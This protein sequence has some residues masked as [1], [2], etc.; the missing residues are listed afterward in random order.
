MTKTAKKKIVDGV[1]RL[2]QA[3]INARA[4]KPKE[5]HFTFQRLRKHGAPDGRVIRSLMADH[6]YAVWQ[7]LLVMEQEQKLPRFKRAPFYE[8]GEVWL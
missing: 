1:R 6:R 8:P 5:D 4:A 7:A 3:L 2:A